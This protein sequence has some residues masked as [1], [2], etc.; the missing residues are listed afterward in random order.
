MYVYSTEISHQRNEK[1]SFHASEITLKK[2]SKALELLQGEVHLS[3]GGK[4]YAGKISS[5]PCI[6]TIYMKKRQKTCFRNC[7]FIIIII[8]LEK[9]FH[10]IY[11]LK[12]PPSFKEI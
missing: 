2:V 5:E 7:G 8:I 9:D 3:V 1:K 12:F 11:S 10:R 6:E 4:N